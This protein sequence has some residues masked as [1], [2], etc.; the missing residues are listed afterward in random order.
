MNLSFSQRWPDGT[1]TYF[2][3]SI[4]LCLEKER[5]SP[6]IKYAAR[7]EREFNKPL[8]QSGYPR[9]KLTTIRSDPH[10]RWYAGRPIHF[11]INPRSKNYFRFYPVIPAVSVQELEI[12]YSPR[13][14]E[15]YQIEYKGQYI[16]IKVDD[17]ILSHSKIVQ[18]YMYDRFL[19]LSS[20]LK[21]F[22]PDYKGRIIHW[23][24][25]TY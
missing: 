7:Y 22:G 17:Q 14:V 13:Q 8:D 23:T 19:N 4:L 16:C 2:I 18:L 9:P 24:D 5:K 11:C 21:Y 25:L 6:F 15:P 1:P 20:F 12:L 10:H 3:Q